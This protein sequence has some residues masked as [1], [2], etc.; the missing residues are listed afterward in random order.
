[1]ALWIREQSGGR[2]KL[3]QV[4][5]LHTD[6][7]SFDLIIANPQT[8]LPARPHVLRLTLPLLYSSVSAIAAA[9]VEWRP[10]L[11]SLPRPWTALLVGGSTAPFVLDARA[12][13]NLMETVRH[14]GGPAGG[15]LLVTTSRRTS[16]A[17]AEAIAELMPPSGFFHRW[18]DNGGSNPYLALLGLADRFVVTGDSIS[19]LVE[20]ARQGKPLAIYSLPSRM[21]SARRRVQR[22]LQAVLFPPAR[23]EGVVAESWRTDLGNSLVRWGLLKY[24]RDFSLFHRLLIEAGLAVRWGE[25]FRP[26]EGFPDDELPRVVARVK[27]LFGSDAGARESR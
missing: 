6:F 11:A 7:D 17:V 1:V 24:R 26:I 5:K 14:A 23:T 18:A 4:G 8:H 15:S 10:R 2:T 21:T 22:V 20:V 13:R 27:G 9:A 12:A 16:A 25:P 19:M 3:V